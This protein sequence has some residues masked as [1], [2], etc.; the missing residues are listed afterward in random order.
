MGASLIHTRSFGGSAIEFC[1]QKEQSNIL[2]SSDV[3]CSRFCFSPSS[4]AFVERLF[5]VCGIHMPMSTSESWCTFN[6]ARI[7]SD[8][9]IRLRLPTVSI[10][11]TENNLST[12]ACDVNRVTTVIC[13][14]TDVHCRYVVCYNY[15]VYRADRQ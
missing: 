3:D 10:P 5:S 11:Q 6:H 15:N 8:L 1:H 12:N 13:T 9:L 14:A 2:L 7:F 4:Q